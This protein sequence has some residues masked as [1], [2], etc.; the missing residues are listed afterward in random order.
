MSTLEAIIMTVLIYLQNPNIHNKKV[1]ILSKGEDTKGNYIVFDKTILYPQGGGQPCDRGSVTINKI[2]YAI[3]DVRHSEGEVRH[4]GDFKTE[5]VSQDDEALLELD[6]K[7]R[8]INT[9]YHT[10][11]HLI[12]AVVEKISPGLTATKGHQFPNESYIEFTGDLNSISENFISLIQDNVNKE[13][14]R[15]KDVKIIYD[16][17][18]F[19]E[20]IPD[21]LNKQS[22]IRF[23]KIGDFQR[24][25]CGGTHVS[26]LSQIGKTVISKV[27]VKKDRIKISYGVH[28]T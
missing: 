3:T 18:S 7:R 28:P 11:G 23:C 4:Y 12:G 1:K 21:K 16:T 14:L 15:D 13:I 27:K 20:N 2:T 26:R 17:P 5:H 8:E 19:Q 6:H 22:R 25:P 10:A 9:R 24:A